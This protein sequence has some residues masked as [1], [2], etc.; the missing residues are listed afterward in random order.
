MSAGFEVLR[1]GPLTTVQ[2][3]GRGG[4]RWM[5][6][7]P[8]GAAD[9]AA[10]GRANALVGNSPGA[11]VLEATFGGVSLRALEAATLAVTG[12]VCEG[13][14]MDVAFVLEAGDTLTLD[15]PRSGLRTYVAVAGGIDVEPVL[16]SRST[17]TL[18]GLGP[19]YLV[20]GQVLAVGGAPTVPGATSA[21]APPALPSLVVDLEF[22]P[23]PRADWLPAAAWRGLDDMSWE[24]SPES[25]RVAVRFHG[26][27]TS[28]RAGSI[29]P[30]PLMR[31]AVQIPPDGRPIVFLADHPVTGGYPVVAV[32]T[33][34]SRDLI[35]QCRPGTSVRLVSAHVDDDSGAGAAR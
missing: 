30:E 7:S 9:R 34:S 22:T 14:S 12:A 8:S 19:P 18:S 10:M 33:P 28:I 29:P 31:G 2:D 24:V 15:A 4:Y 23:G 25:N 35:A 17:D 13:A 21:A 27:A 6:V 26:A 3:L 11:A 20:A 1:S 16:G 32:L 5:G